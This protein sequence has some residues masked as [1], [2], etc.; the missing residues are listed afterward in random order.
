MKQ[1]IDADVASMTQAEKTMLRYQYVMSNARLAMGDFA[2][3]ADTWANVVRTLKQQFQQLGGIIGGTLINAIK[4]ALIGLRNFMQQVLDFAKTVA[5]ALGAIFGWTIEITASGSGAADVYE[6]LADSVDDAGSGAGDVGKGLGD[7][8]KAAKAIEKSLS[9]LPFDELN[10]LAKDTGG[11]SG[12]GGSGGSGGGSGGSGG[13]GGMSGNGAQAALVRTDSVL[14]KITSDIKTLEDLGKYISD[15]LVKAMKSIN[16]SEIYANARNFGTGL[17]QF[18]NGLITPELFGE[19]AK[20]I[21]R[22]I[23]TAMYAINSF[24]TEFNWENLGESIATGI[25]NFFEEF[26]AVTAG[27]NINLI[28]NGLLDAIYKALDTIKWDKV[29]E[30]IGTFFE[31]IDEK[32]I[33][34]S[35]VKVLG[36]AWQG[37]TT[38]WQKSFDTAPVE[39]V[40]ITGVAAAKF[41]GLDKAL[42]GAIVG[43]MSKTIGIGAIATAIK[44]SLFP[45]GLSLGSLA[46]GLEGLTMSVNPAMIGMVGSEIVDKISEWID[47]HIGTGVSEAIG[48]GLMGLTGAAI[49]TMIAPGIGTLVGGIGGLILA[50]LANPVLVT[51]IKKGFSGLFSNATKDLASTFGNIGKSFESIHYSIDILLSKIRQKIDEWLLGM[52]HDHPFLATLLGI[53]E[54]DIKVAINAEIKS[55][56]DLRKKK[57]RV[58]DE[59]AN[60]T[61]TDYSNLTDSQKTVETKA[62]IYDRR[63]S[64]KAAAPIK[65]EAILNSQRKGPNFNG[66]ITGM[67]AVLAGH[68]KGVGFSS[69][70][71]AMTSEFG[72]WQKGKGWNNDINMNSA[73]VN[74]Y[75]ARGWGNDINMNS[76]F[77]SWYKARGYS[78][79]IGGM[80]AALRDWYKARGFDSNITMTAKIT[81]AFTAGAL[82]GARIITGYNGGIFKPGKGFTPFPS[83]ASGGFP[84]GGQIFRARENGNPELV[85]TLKGS[86]AVMNNNQIVASVSDGVAKAIAGIRFQMTG[87]RPPEIDYN[88]LQGVIQ[89]AVVSALANNATERPIDVY[90]TIKTQNDEVLARAVARGNR[91]MNYRDS[92]V[93]G[94]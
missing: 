75:K 2:A 74:W 78:N 17:A 18:L 69:V 45:N 7:G 6:G 92:A 56:K 32:K 21:A 66:A 20:L 68:R 50:E 48:N 62:D 5:D 86:T 73:F 84:Y 94:A 87:F 90:A 8:A 55:Q 44:T 33:T 89:Y 88:G 85:G 61:D 79:N 3:T 46:L 24:A 42:V 83:F 34:E 22:S 4:P 26:D 81:H 51:K 30:D 40:I 9:V 60:V 47:E 59:L 54:A 19:T 72:M 64:N 39:T 16:W 37:V 93:A 11:G 23:N 58:L 29:G 14:E 31:K 52:V 80:I 10:Q 76:A 91:S 15:S 70:I 67:E 65:T 82:A 38:A 43:Y 27:I 13:G 71:G 57:D 49:G 35:L 28:A 77:V 12:S 25:N 41:T 36:R 63:V 1:G 53:S